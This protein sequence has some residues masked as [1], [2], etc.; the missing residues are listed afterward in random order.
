MINATDLDRTAVEDRI[1]VIATQLHALEAELVIALSE[2]DAL[3]GWQC[4]DF[5]TMAN[6]MTIRTGH[7]LVDAERLSGC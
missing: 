1:G 6:W 7:L 2:F 5:Q 4:P 3:G